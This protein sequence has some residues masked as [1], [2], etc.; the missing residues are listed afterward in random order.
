M[1]ISE[2]ERTGAPSPL[3]SAVKLR[4]SELSQ[5]LAELAVRVVGRPILGAVELD[6]VPTDDV[7]REYLWSLQSTIAAGHVADSAQPDRAAHPR[8]AE[9]PL[10]CAGS[11]ASSRFRSLSNS[12]RSCGR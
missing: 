3:G 4:Y 7:A 6:G 9:G 10:R 1:C 5:E 2:A 12:R 11:S 8:D